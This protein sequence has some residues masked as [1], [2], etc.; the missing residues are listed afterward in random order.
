ML[1]CLA[2][3]FTS[4]AQGH[5]G[6]R[7]NEVMVKNDS[8]YIDDYG[9]K[10]A[11]IELYNSTY[12]VMKME[13][14]FLTNDKNNPTMYAVPRGDIKTNIPARQHVVFF[15]DGEPN[16]GTFHLNFVLKPGQENWIGL[17][18]A[19]GKTLIDEVTIP[20]NLPSNATYAV[21]KD[22]AMSED[23]SFDPSLWE[24]RDGS[25]EKY[26]TPSS[27]NIIIDVNE[28]ILK[29]KTHDPDGIVLTLMAM[30]IVFS[31]LILLSLCFYFF[32]KLNEHA[33]KRNKAK[34]HKGDS[35]TPEEIIS[36]EED[37]GEEIAA[38]TMALYQHLNAHDIEDTILTINKVRRAYSPWSSKIY[39]LRENPNR[40]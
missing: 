23:G 2:L 22:G 34:A 4:F 21:I 26:I 35:V 24:I 32:G 20:A 11:W 10:H 29:F 40:H 39:T 16:K 38:I 5:K 19:D 3:T 31:A 18:D 8:N 12:N 7:I 9:M 30:G 15:A 1:A 28:N 33:A 13:S 25:A 36:V 17:Y 6:L 14:M 27:N 37:S